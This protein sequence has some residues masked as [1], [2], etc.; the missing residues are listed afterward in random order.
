MKNIFCAIFLMFSVTVFAQ[1]QFA[2]ISE[3]GSSRTL[4]YFQENNDLVFI[5][6]DGQ[7]E[8]EIKRLHFEST[9]NT[10]R[11]EGDQDVYN[12]ELLRN[13]TEASGSAYQ[14]CWKNKG[15]SSD[16]YADFDH[17]INAA[18]GFWFLLFPGLATVSLCAVGP[19]VPFI[20]GVLA[21]PID[22]AITLSDRIVDPDAIAVRKFSKLLRGKNKKAS[23]L[24]FES[25]I[26]QIS[27]L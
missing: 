27:E 14:W 26:N 22:G 11:I 17:T 13:M 20:V 2:Q 5:F 25:L 15:Q 10:L 24:V 9:S 21:A 6:K 19:A 4:T 8:K 3:R 12:F 1:T 7:L 18:K 16:G 23:K